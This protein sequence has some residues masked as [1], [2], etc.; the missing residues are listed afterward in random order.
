MSHGVTGSVFIAIFQILSA[1]SLVYFILSSLEG[2]IVFVM[3]R[4]ICI[5]DALQSM[6]RAENGSGRTFGSG[7]VWVRP[8]PVARSLPDL[9]RGN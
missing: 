1:E 2:L 5:P 7:K 9:V 3:P 4:K 8:D 6:A